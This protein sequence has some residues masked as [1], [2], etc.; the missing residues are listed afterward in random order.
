MHTEACPWPSER[1]WASARELLA[2]QPAL[3]AEVDQTLS[4]YPASGLYADEA[5]ATHADETTI[6]SIFCEHVISALAD[7]PRSKLLRALDERLL[8]LHD[9]SSEVQQLHAEL[10][11][12]RGVTITT[13][14]DSVAALP[15]GKVHHAWSVALAAA[16]K[17]DTPLDDQNKNRRA[18]EGLRAKHAARGLPPPTEAEVAAM[19]RRS[20]DTAAA[21]AAAAREREATLREELRSDAAYLRHERVTRLWEE[22]GVAALWR[23]FT[24]LDTAE[25]RERQSRGSGFEAKR[26]SV[27]FAMLVPLLFE[28]T[29]SPVG[30]AKGVERG[31]GD[32]P[33]E[34]GAHASRAPRGCPG[35]PAG[36]QAALA[37]LRSRSAHPLSTLS[38]EGRAPPA[39]LGHLRAFFQRVAP[40]H[41]R[42]PPEQLRSL[43]SPQQPAPARPER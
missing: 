26:A 5:E 24:A 18:V 41:P 21:A 15:K 40:P 20:A 39:S 37:A 4:S 22:G 6:F 13:L 2:L 11:L 29:S 30:G 17:P 43:R 38:E 7:S 16:E 42:A 8:A 3:R 34:P 25:G 19:L 12:P 28:A 14:A 10:G 35:R 27:C 23:E 9:A 33:S 1:D 31:W 32:G 36:L